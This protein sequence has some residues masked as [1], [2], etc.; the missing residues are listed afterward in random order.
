MVYPTDLEVETDFST[1]LA[2]PICVLL[3]KHEGAKQSTGPIQ[4]D[5]LELNAPN[6]QNSTFAGIWKP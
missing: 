5:S 1:Q 3:S 4:E 2:E 6:G